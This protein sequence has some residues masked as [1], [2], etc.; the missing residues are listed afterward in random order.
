[1]SILEIVKMGDP[2]LAIEASQVTDFQHEG[3]QQSISDMVDTMRHY[4]GVGLAAPQIGLSKQILVLEVESNER[5]PEA[6]AIELD[7]LINPEIIALSEEQ[8]S[9]WEGCLSLP[10]LRGK[11]SRAAQITY[12]AQAPSGEWL[13]KTVKGFH[14][15]I[16]QHEIDHLKGILYPQ[17]LS[18]IHD[19]GFEDSL[20]AF[21]KIC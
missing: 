21:K 7:I 2:A 18:D 16:I 15:R 11:V 4:R 12:R 19:F 20:P 9:A 13:E 17:R 3:L 8:E 1:M 14:A 10:D 5:Y 6:E